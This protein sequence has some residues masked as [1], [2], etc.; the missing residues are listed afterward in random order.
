MGGRDVEFREILLY[1]GLDQSIVLVHE[2]N[3]SLGLDL[4]GLDL[5]QSTGSNKRVNRKPLLPMEM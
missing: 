4:C 3:E 2:A 1:Q 5:L